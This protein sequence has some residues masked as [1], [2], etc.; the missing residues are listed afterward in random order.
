MQRI[1]LLKFLCDELLNSTNIREHLE[2]CASVSV[3]L[4]QKIRSLS[5]EWRNLKFREE[6]LTGKVARDKAS[7]LSGTGKCGTEGVATLYPHY[8]KLMRQPSGGGG[9][10]SS[11]AS[12]L[13]LSEDGLQLNESRKL[14]CWFNSKGISM[15]QPSCSRNQ[16]GE[17]P[18]TESQVHQESEK[19][20][21]RVD[22][23]QYDVPHSASQPQKQDTAGEYA[24][25]RNKGQDLENG[26]TSGPLQ[27]NCEASQSHFSSDHTNGNQVAEHLC[28]MP[29]NPENIVPGH[30]SIVQ[31]DM[32]EPHAH[33]LKGSVLKNE[34]AVLQDSIAGLESQQLA[35]S[36]RKELLGRDSAGRLYW[37]FFRPNT[38]PWLLVDATTVLEQERILKEHGDS[39]ANSPF[40]EEYN[41]I[42]ASSSWFSYQSDTEI[43][44]LIQ[45]LSDSDPR[46]KELA[47]SILRWT[48]IGY[49]DLKI[50][51]NHIED[52]SVPSSSKCRK[53]EATVKSSGL[54]TKALTVLEEKHG[55]CLE[56]EVL[57]M[58]MKLDTNSEL[59]CKE[60]MY[61]CEC[62]E[63]VL[64]TRFHCR[65]CH[66][67]FSARNE[68]EE[69]NDAKCILSATSSQN[70]KED[71]E[72]TK[73]AGTIRTETLQ[74]ECME[75]AGK[76]MSQSLKHGTAMGSFEIP[77]EFACPFNFE[78]ISTKFI[79]KNS[80]KELVQE[81][82]LIGSNGVPA[83]VPS[84]SPYLCD[85]S[86]KLVEMCKNEINRG[87]KSTN[88]ENL[89]QYSIAGDMVSG[90]EHDNISNNSSRR[91]TVSHNDDDVL[92]S[93]RLNPNFMNE[94]RDQSFNLR[95][96]KPGI[97]NR[98]IVRDTSL[99]PLMGRGIE[100]LRQLKINLLD[101]DAAVP[102]EALRSSK[103]C[104]ENRSAWR[105]FVKSAK[106][107]F[108]VCMFYFTSKILIPH[109]G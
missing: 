105:A 33:D 83:F 51:G 54:V 20:N 39:L 46:D 14:S 73:G 31:H 40:E 95:S 108:E 36:L 104:W 15:R 5:L 89:F 37:A 9:Y 67:S 61:R 107:I 48:K 60:R 84:T 80:I 63:P 43:E 28:V 75:T 22:D 62:L 99:M 6:I 52:E 30:H 65:R 70:S 82:G 24:T 103:A 29:M 74:A 85:P 102:E 38:S 87:N 1:F 69:H 90:L 35:V 86:L 76:G 13:A 41:G 53:S 96:L 71:D 7:V 97:G 10:F 58:S 44:E 4:Q 27:P 68:L 77:K 12:D 101:M 17:A 92:K 25:W 50:A 91:C 79:T 78:E 3:D 19:D 11:F 16:I 18:Y 72:R 26:H 81:I 23:L 45:W 64:P 93:R 98:S 94:K 8:G 49:K 106:S 57:K 100:I 42:S 21:I 2:R 66:L 55:P 34:I 88:L 32:N 109:F 59:T 47:E 56:P